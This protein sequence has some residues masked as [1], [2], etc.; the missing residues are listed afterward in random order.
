[1]ATSITKFNGKAVTDPSNVASMVKEK[2]PGDQVEITY[3]PVGQKKEKK[4]NVKLGE[5]ENVEYFNFRTPRPITAPNPKFYGAPEMG[6]GEKSKTIRSQ[7]VA[8]SIFTMIP[9]GQCWA[10][11]SR[12]WKILPE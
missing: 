10:L 11:K 12:T 9:K 2:K 4:I 8:S 1:M 3:L 7:T 6:P 5:T